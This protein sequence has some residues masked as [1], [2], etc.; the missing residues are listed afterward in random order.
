MMSSLPLGKFQP[1]ARVSTAT[2]SGW[3]AGLEA[4]RDCLPSCMNQRSPC[5]A[6]MRALQRRVEQVA[7]RIAAERELEAVTGA[8]V[9]FGARHPRLVRP[10]GRVGRVVRVE[11]RP[12]F[13]AVVAA[14]RVVE[15]GAGGVAREAVHRSVTRL[16]DAGDVDAGPEDVLVGG[17]AG[18]DAAAHRRRPRGA[19]LAGREDAALHPVRREDV[20]RAGEEAEPP[21]GLRL[22]HGHREAVAHSAS[23]A[24]AAR[25]R[26]R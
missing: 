11:D 16:D 8:V 12:D 7:L 9:A 10:D 21:S 26:T 6:A 18:P 3:A 19:D 17:A 13:L 1:S 2:P 5:D 15:E 24:T 14:G 25:I 22:R 23:T 20:L 4:G